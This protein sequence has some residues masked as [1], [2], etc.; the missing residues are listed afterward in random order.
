MSNPPAGGGGGGRGPHFET[1]AGLVLDLYRRV[2]QG[3]PLLPDEY[4]VCSEE[5]TSIQA[6]RRLAASCPPGAV[7]TP[8]DS[9]SLSEVQ[10]R[11]LSF[12]TRYE[13]TAQPFK[14]TFTRE[15]LRDLLSKLSAGSPQ[16]AAA[17]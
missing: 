9:S 16:R 3:T 2:W 13:E 7:L 6:R 5:K 12:Q 1:K 15:D 8:N 11:L 14:W 17:A 4:A 10:D